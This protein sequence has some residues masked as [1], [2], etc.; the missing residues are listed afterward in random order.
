MVPGVE[1]FGHTWFWGPGFRGLKLRDWG[2]GLEQCRGWGPVR[3]RG[4]TN[5]Y[6]STITIIITIAIFVSICATMIIVTVNIASITSCII[7]IGI[8]T[9]IIIMMTG[10]VWNLQRRCPERKRLPPEL[11]GL[12]CR[13]WFSGSSGSR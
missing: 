2:S 4:C 6:S 5:Y 9:A 10:L 1:G 12:G 11:H 3:S 13:V 7:S 8:M